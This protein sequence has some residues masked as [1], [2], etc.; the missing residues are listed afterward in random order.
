M[1]TTNRMAVAEYRARNKVK[2]EGR[3][4][5]A[6]RVSHDGKD[7]PSKLERDWWIKL[8]LMQEQGLI[9]DLKFQVNIPLHGV[10]DPLLTKTGR[11]MQYR[12]DFTYVENGQMVIA[13]AKGFETEIFQMKRAVLAAARIKV[14]TLT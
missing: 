9:S 5:A 12:A 7:F 13:D 2:R 10:Y 6:K 4:K 8:S 11:V 3:V 1:T 14:K